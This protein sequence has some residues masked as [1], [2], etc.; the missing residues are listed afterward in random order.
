MK[1]AHYIINEEHPQFAEL[2]QVV[3]SGL[4]NAAQICRDHCCTAEETSLF[5]FDFLQGIADAHPDLM[6]PQ[7]DKSELN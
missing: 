3:I 7:F 1:V 5:I 4:A 2:E 6:W